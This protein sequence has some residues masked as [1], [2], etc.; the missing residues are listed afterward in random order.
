MS[1]F[2]LLLTYIKLHLLT[3]VECKVIKIDHSP[4]I[5]QLTV[6]LHLCHHFISRLVEVSVRIGLLGRDHSARDQ[7]T[8]L[9]LVIKERC[10]D[11]LA[12]IFL[13]PILVT[14]H[15]CHRRTSSIVAS[16]P[17]SPNPDIF[18]GVGLF[19]CQCC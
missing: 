12:Q 4:S 16:L 19:L 7:D 17:S 11:Q 2:L 3:S 5:V 6:N 15:Q 9:G 13:W 14:F 1:I 10:S 18:T 8:N